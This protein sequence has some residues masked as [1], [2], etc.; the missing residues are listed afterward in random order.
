MKEV[1]VT[2]P[3]R[4][5]AEWAA[6]IT[7]A[8]NKVHRRGP[9]R[10]RGEGDENKNVETPLARFLQEYGHHIL[11]QV[12]CAGGRI[13]ILDTTTKELIECKARGNGRSLF[14]AAVQLK[15]YQKFYSD[16]RLVIAIPAVESDD[17]WL[18]E[19]FHAVGFRIFE[20]E[21]LCHIW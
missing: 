3:D 19:A 14:D 4:T 2:P 1:A 7:T 17:K 20:V 5:P 6:T 10:S 13:D 12:P 11:R 18:A 8:W 16:H 9:K 15:H 21:R